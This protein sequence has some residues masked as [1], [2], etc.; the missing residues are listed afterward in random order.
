MIITNP[1]EAKPTIRK[2]SFIDSK[3]VE[4]FPARPTPLA[5]THF[6]MGY[7][8]P[9]YPAKSPLPPLVGTIS[10]VPPF[11][12]PFAPQLPPMVDPANPPYGFNFPPC[13]PS[14]G[15]AV[16]APVS[17]PVPAHH[18]GLW[19]VAKPSVPADTLQ[20]ALDYACGEGGADCEAITP[21]GSCYFPDTI[22]AHASYALNSYWQKN[23]NNGGTCGF[24]GTAMLVTSDPSF[25]HCR[26]LLN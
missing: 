10:P 11:T 9:A 2:L 24:G 19:C 5:P 6:P 18:N 15:G 14:A 1:K 16:A 8:V 3:F 20:Q 7:S 4:S 21:Q 25:R 22:V 17:V 26:F 13:N 23:K 12:L